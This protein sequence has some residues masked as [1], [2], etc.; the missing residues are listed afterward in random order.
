MDPGPR[1]DALVLLWARQLR[2][3]DAWNAARALR[4]RLAAEP[5]LVPRAVEEVLRFEPITPFT[6]RLVWSV[7]GPAS[8]L[9]TLSSSGRPRDQ[10]PSPLS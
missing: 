10:V 5:G 1:R 7:R 4:E 3:I 6:A 9:S 8:E 2:A